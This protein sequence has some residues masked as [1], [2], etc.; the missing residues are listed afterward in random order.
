MR[1]RSF[2]ISAFVLSLACLSCEPKENAEV[3]VCA[4][5]GLVKGRCGCDSNGKRIPEVIDISTGRLTCEASE[6]E[7][8]DLCPFDDNKT[9]PGI[10]GCGLSDAKNDKGEAWCEGL[11]LCPEDDE[12]TRPG[13]CGCG[14]SDEDIDMNTKLPACLSDQIDLCPNDETKVVPGVCGCGVNDDDIDPNFNI[15]RCLSEKVDLCPNSDKVVPGICGCDVVDVDKDGDGVMDCIDVCPDDPEKTDSAGICGCGVSETD[16]HIRDDDGDTVANCIDVCPSNPYKWADDTCY[17]S[18]GKSDCS[19]LFTVYEAKPLCA[20]MIASGEGFIAVR[21]AWNEGEY[22]SDGSKDPVFILVEDIDI[23]DYIENPSEWVGIGTEEYPFNG[24]FLGQYKSVQHSISA[25]SGSLP[26][27]LGSEELD[28]VGLF[29][30]VSYGSGDGDLSGSKTT[31]DGIN[32]DLSVIGRDNV[33]I[34]AG[35][36]DNVNVSHVLATG[37]ASGVNHVGGLVGMS[38]VSAFESVAANARVRGS[39]EDIGG[40]I[41]LT[42]NSSKIVKSYVAGSGVL[43]NASE[44]SLNT[45]GLIGRA[46]A[47][48]VNNAY[49]S[50]ELNGY[51]NSGGFIGSVEGASSILNT[52]ALTEMTCH[53]EPCGGFV[54]T[55][56]GASIVKN[57][58]STGHVVSEVPEETQTDEQGSTEDPGSKSPT[59]GINGDSGTEP[60]TDGSGGGGESVT[61]GTEGGDGGESGGKTTNGDNSCD[62]IGIGMLIGAVCGENTLENLY[63]WFTDSETASAPVSVREALSPFVYLLNV[64]SISSDMRL[65]DQLNKNLTCAANVCMIDATVCDR[66]NTTTFRIDGKSMTIPALTYLKTTY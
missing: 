64:A 24:I 36:V 44:A 2:Y 39:G 60:G 65:S 19:R 55:L 32:V 61:P 42:T 34:L 50:G 45:G 26:V 66:W 35:R 56:S 54:G 40:L 33:G 41:G 49:A 18:D 53:A 27:I 52:Y 31:I 22:S 58:Y 14:I 23:G 62:S 59:E 38:S 12:K 29:G 10:C 7:D 25:T 46:T 28:N 15:P 9:D 17:D 63:Y 57:A 20:H 13:I 1:Q 47:T 16:E 3:E 4:S 6:T 48:V 21:D 5:D 11:D 37:S 30:V 43:I 51:K 8:V